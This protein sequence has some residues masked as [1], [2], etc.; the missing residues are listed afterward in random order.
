MQYPPLAPQPAS[1]S[2]SGARRTS[3]RSHSSESDLLER[4]CELSDMTAQIPE[5]LER[6][7]S[8]YEAQA[9]DR[10]AWDRWMTSALGREQHKTSLQLDEKQRQLDQRQHDLELKQRQMELIRQQRIQDVV[11]VQQPSLRPTGITFPDSASGPYSAATTVGTFFI[12][13]DTWL[14]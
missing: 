1:T 6:V 8:N 12:L 7:I 11:T 3:H 13:T 5:R 10:A 2:T 4:L 9:N 14:L